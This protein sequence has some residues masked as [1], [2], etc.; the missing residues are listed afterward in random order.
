MV[1][2]GCI[3]LSKIIAKVLH[4]ATYSTLLD[5][6]CAF[7]FN[8]SPTAKVIWRRVHGLKSNPTDW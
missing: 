2:F 3:M 6:Y 4:M 1:L 5:V 7:V 8:V